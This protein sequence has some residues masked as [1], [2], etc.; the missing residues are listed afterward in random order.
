MCRKKIALVGFR[1][2]KGGAERVMATLS[3]FFHEKRIE[4]HVIIVLDDIA[5]PHSGVV[6][7]LGKLKN[8]NNGILNKIE[9]FLFLKKYLKQHKFDFIIDFRFRVKPIQEL[10]ISKWLY[11]TKTIYTV[12]SSKLEVYMPN[13]SPLTRL[14]YNKSYSV[15]SITMSM[16]KMI[17]EKHK[18]KNVITIYNPI[19]ISQIRQ[20][21]SEKISLDY[22]YIIGV[23]QYNTNVKQFDKL[24]KA[25]SQS[26]LPSKNIQLV[27]LGTGKLKKYLLEIV[28]D[29]GVN[30][31]VHMLGFKDNPYKY[32]KNAKFFILTSKFEGLAMVMLE[33]LACCTPVISFDCPTGPNEIIAHKENGLLIENQNIYKLIKGMNALVNDDELYLRCKNNTLESVEKFSINTIGQQWLDLMNYN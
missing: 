30:H 32:L 19:D 20:K 6:L 26:E 5:Y 17:K 3:N 31:L 29:C 7:N 28:Q 25:Y 11:N 33:A 13:Y 24:I 16:Q 21:S 14:I 23:G 1:L 9:R 2:N 27:I 18:L 4:V 10:L 12:H 22:E 15:V 8:E